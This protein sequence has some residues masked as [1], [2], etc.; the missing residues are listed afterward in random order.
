MFNAH[1]WIKLGMNRKHLDIM[2]E[3]SQ[4]KYDQLDIELNEKIKARLED[5]VATNEIIQYNFIDSLNNIE[6]FLSIQLSRNHFNSTLRGFYK[7]INEISDGS[8]GVLYELDDENENFNPEKPYKVWRL[9]G[10]TF[11]EC[12]EKI[13]NDKY[14]IV[15]Y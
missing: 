10:R 11:E 12:E 4:I 2:D 7:W 13:I 6:S 5:I 9:I 3:E 14:H 1:G 15:N 8:H